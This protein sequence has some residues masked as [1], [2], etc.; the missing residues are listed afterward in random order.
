MNEALGYG[1]RVNRDRLTYATG[2]LLE[3]RLLACMLSNP[4]AGGGSLRDAFGG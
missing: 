1:D 4:G 2:A 3:E